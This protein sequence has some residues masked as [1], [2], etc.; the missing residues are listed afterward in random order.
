[1]KKND[2]V[3]VK[4]PP[5]PQ[6][7][8]EILALD[9]LK[10]DDQDRLVSIIC[11]DPV[12]SAKIVSIANSAL[13]GYSGIT[14][15]KES[16]QRIGISFAHK[17]SL[18]ISFA[19]INSKTGESQYSNDIMANNIAM[20]SI[21]LKLFEMVGEKPAKSDLF[22]SVLLHDI[23]LIL[24]EAILPEKFKALKVINQDKRIVKHEALLM[25]T[26]LFGLTHAEA[27]AELLDFWGISQD[28]SEAVRFH[29]VDD[30]NKTLNKSIT[31]KILASANRI[32]SY[33]FSDENRAEI[34]RLL[35][36]SAQRYDAAFAEA[37]KAS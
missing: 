31:V 2:I 25:E 4:L 20:M 37:M 11:K 32:M 12:L 35:G 1:M 9:M 36:I 34:C 24:F 29:E 13:Y 30:L 17:I 15:V 28:I 10:D 22:L 14:S 6:S 16:I 7:A 26:N 3:M 21:V 18:G 33:G 27:G 19:A 5:M 23:G 8:R